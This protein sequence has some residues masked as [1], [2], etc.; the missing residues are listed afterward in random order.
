M[1]GYMYIMSDKNYVSYSIHGNFLTNSESDLKY[2][3]QL[4]GVLITVFVSLCTLCSRR[5]KQSVILF[6]LL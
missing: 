4:S 5:I 6:L 1:S 3:P 2:A